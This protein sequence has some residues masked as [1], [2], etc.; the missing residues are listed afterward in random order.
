[1]S[2]PTA[3]EWADVLHRALPMAALVPAEVRYFFVSPNGQYVACTTSAL[4][5]VLIDMQRR[6]YAAFA[7]WSVRALTDEAVELE[8]DETRMQA[9]PVYADLWQMA[10]TDA[11][12][13]WQPALVD[14]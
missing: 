13:P 14:R 2:T 12:L 3:P 9:F 7:D 11:T 8:S 5:S 1:M 6:R 4:R 10:L